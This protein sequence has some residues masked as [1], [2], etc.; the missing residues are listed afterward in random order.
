MIESKFFS[1]TI[2]FYFKDEYSLFQLKRCINSIRKQTFQNFEIIIGTSNYFWELKNNS[3]F[4]RINIINTNKDV[5]YIQDNIN[6]ALNASKGK[7]NKI[8][9]SDDYFLEK[10]ELEKLYRFIDD[11]SY[12]WIIANSVHIKK[13]DKKLIK[14]LLP[15]YQKDILSINTIGSPSAIAFKNNYSLFFDEKSWMRLD[16]DFYQ[17]LYSSFG[18]P[19]YANNIFIVNE[20]HNNQESFILKKA[21]HSTKNKLKKE[22]NYLSKK[23][24]YKLPSKFKLFFYKKYVKFERIFFSFLFFNKQFQNTKIKAPLIDIFKLI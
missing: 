7:W 15:Y 22:L 16:V 6:S 10:S 11:N 8:L 21:S 14:P 1:V 17:T 4:E 12:S 9:F 23:H 19:G 13:N 20:I 18:R 5:C 24:K 3:F 2:P